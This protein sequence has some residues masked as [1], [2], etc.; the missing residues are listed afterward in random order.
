VLEGVADKLTVLARRYDGRM[1]YAH[2]MRHDRSCWL[3]N[4]CTVPLLKLFLSWSEAY[5]GPVESAL[6]PIV[7]ACSDRFSSSHIS[8]PPAA[9]AA[10][11]GKVTFPPVA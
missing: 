3:V 4:R 6:A 7:S 8:S 11:S 9:A 10:A 5:A 1:C 2:H